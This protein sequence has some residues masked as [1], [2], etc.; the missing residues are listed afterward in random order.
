MREIIE[1]AI[2]VGREQQS[3]QTGYV[4]CGQ[5]IPI[6][7]NLLFALSLLR[8]RRSENVLEAKRLLDGLLHFQSE[9]GNFPIYLHQ[10]PHCQ[11]YWHGGDLLLTFYW[12]LKGY[13]TVLGEELS[14]RLVRAVTALMDYVLELGSQG[15]KPSLRLLKVGAAAVGF[16]RLWDKGEW[17]ELGA[18]FIQSLLDHN[19]PFIWYSPS[20]LGQMMA[21]L[22]LVDQNLSCYPA[23]LEH[24]SSLWH[25]E[26][27]TY[28]GPAYKEHQ[29]GELPQV[30]LL[31]CFFGKPAKGFLE[32]SLAQPI[33]SPIAFPALPFEKRDSDSYLL[34]HEHYAYAAIEQKEPVDPSKGQGFYPFRLVW[35]SGE[36]LNHLVCSAPTAT[37]SFQTTEDGVVLELTLP[38]EAPDSG[39][40]ARCREVNVF[41]NVREGLKWTV[42]GVPATT[43][44]LG[45]QLNVQDEAFGCSILCEKVSGDG[46]FFGHLM[47]GNRPGQLLAKGEDRFDAY[48]WHLFVRTV[49]RQDPCTLRLTLSFSG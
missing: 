42:G 11:D 14:E 10:Y 35:P 20:A 18:P 37:V 1:K 26:F 8:S 47:R 46:E 2:G 29:S 12:V 38:E 5:T 25:Q 44:Q 32:A 13:R 24:I 9:N 30:T 21:A 45:D 28:V 40:R 4:H 15:K 3:E 23:L 6:K 33:E 48:D 22:Q 34:Q 36:E 49:R 27:G 7:E 41:V 16:G 43:F 31:D 17:E 19:D 39:D